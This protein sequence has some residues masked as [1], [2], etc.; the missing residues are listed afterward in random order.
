V[1]D[2]GDDEPGL[3]LAS[4]PDEKV[5][6]AQEAVALAERAAALTGRHDAAEE[7]WLRAREARLDWADEIRQRLEM[8]RRGQPYRAP[9]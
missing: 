2:G 5:R 3:D 4:C 8:Y 1:A 9:R 6:R 7:A